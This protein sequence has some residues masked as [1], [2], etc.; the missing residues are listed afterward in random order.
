MY[1]I[2]LLSLLLLALLS[3]SRHRPPV[4]L[5]QHRPSSSSVNSKNILFFVCVILSNKI[6]WN[7]AAGEKKRSTTTVVDI[8]VVISSL[9]VTCAC[10]CLHFL[11][12]L[13]SHSFWFFPTRK[14]TFNGLNIHEFRYLF[15]TLQHVMELAVVW[16]PSRWLG[17][18]IEFVRFFAAAW[19]QL[20]MAEKA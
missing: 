4:S 1:L 8:V 15:L 2:K 9:P 14:W 18:W 17:S 5:C 11:C 19:T 10:C 6:Y 3:L 20:S 16:L 13:A 7:F 12:L